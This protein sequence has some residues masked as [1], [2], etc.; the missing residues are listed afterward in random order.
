MS[1]KPALEF[2]DTNVL[3][4]AHDRSA[5]AKY[6]AARALL[7]RL[8]ESGT[9]CLSLQVLQ[10]FYVTVTRKVAQPLPLDEAAQIVRDLCFWR[11]YAP[12]SEDLLGAIDFQRQF[13]LSFWDAMVLYA[14]RR[15]DCEVLW[16]EDLSDG[17]IYDTIQVRNPFTLS[18]P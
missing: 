6:S 10:E 9:G 13:Q 12:V 7:Q 1:D 5:G 4:Y 2:V 8:W 16:S 3:V 15:M 17:Q 18:T 11:V 14:A